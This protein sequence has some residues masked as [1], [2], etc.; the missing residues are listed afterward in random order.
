MWWKASEGQL[1]TAMSQWQ[2]PAAVTFGRTWPGPIL[3]S[4]TVGD[5]DRAV[6]QCLHGL[7]S[8]LRLGCGSEGGA[9]AVDQVVAAGDER[10]AL[11]AREDDRFRDLLGEAR[12]SDGCRP[13]SPS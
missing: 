12:T 2:R 9:G 4:G 7:E 13:T 8:L 6:V 10:G 5:A 3:G 1:I 11:G